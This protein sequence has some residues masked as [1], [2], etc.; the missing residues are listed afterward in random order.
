V[1]S[2]RN[3]GNEDNAKEYAFKLLGRRDYASSRLKAKLEKKG[4]SS[5][6]VLR[7]IKY[8]EKTGFLN[9][10]KFALNYAY[11]RLNGKPGGPR[12]LG[13]ELFKKGIPRLLA[14]EVILSV[15]NE[16]SEEELIKKVVKK[17]ISRRKITDEVRHRLYAKLLR[18]GFSCEN[19][20]R[21]LKRYDE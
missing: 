17:E 12:V 6:I 20:E 19:I 5:K 18:R 11:F 10:K 15:Y 16:V 14:D 1:E 3:S 13:Y 9:D 2:K 21:V 4:Y 8:L 7:V